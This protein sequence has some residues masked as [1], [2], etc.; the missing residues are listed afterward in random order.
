MKLLWPATVKHDDGV[1]KDLLVG[2]FEAA[3]G[4]YLTSP[5]SR[6]CWAFLGW[7]VFLHDLLSC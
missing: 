4:W 3:L 2:L 7:N 6:E 5:E 1:K